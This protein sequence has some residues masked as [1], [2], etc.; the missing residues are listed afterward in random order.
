MIVISGMDSI[1]YLI[2]GAGVTGLAFANCVASDRCLILEK[3]A[4]PGGHCRTVRQAG[5]T[6]DYAGH[7]LHFQRP[8]IESFVLDKLRDEDLVRVGKR[9]AIR[10]QGRYVDYPFQQHVGGLPRKDS[11]GGAARPQPASAATTTTG[12]KRMFYERCGRAVAD[13]FLVPYN[14]KVFATDV[15]K[16]EDCALGRF[17]PPGTPTGGEA[18]MDRSYNATFLYP[19]NGACCVIDALLRDILPTRIAYGETVQQVD[20]PSHVAKTNRREIRY[21]RL[22]STAPLTA[23]LRYTGHASAAGTF[24]F[25]QV[26]VLNLGFDRK[27]DERYHWIYFPEPEYPFYR[28]GYYDNVVAADRMSLYVET[29]YS[30]TT[31]IDNDAA[32]NAVMVG[33][34]EAGIVTNHRLIASYP[35]MMTPAYVHTTPSATREFAHRDA[36]WRSHGIY[37][38]G[39]YGGWRYSSIEDCI[40]EARSLAAEIDA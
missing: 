25:S 18:A 3:N 38:I 13:A 29:A 2:I 16:L 11:T 14:E 5:F 15:S 23:L 32:M 24:A 9:A 6:W 20:A 26:L 19:K 22:I 34:R 4:E 27:G 28:V 36:A 1:D 21:G 37:S 39:R 12:L 33:L 30:A 31:T 7:F 10:F 17:F 8:E 40:F 35:V